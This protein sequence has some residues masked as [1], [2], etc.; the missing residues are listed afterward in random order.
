MFHP[1]QQQDQRVVLEAALHVAY[2]NTVTPTL[3]TSVSVILASLALQAIVQVHVC[4][5]D[6][7]SG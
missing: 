5:L 4:T 3:I 6:H 2:T 7:D 1:P